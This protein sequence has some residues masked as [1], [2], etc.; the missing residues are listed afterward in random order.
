MV[1][2]QMQEE[3][4]L[5]Q[6]RGSHTHGAHRLVKRV[7]ACDNYCND[8]ACS[9]LHDSIQSSFILLIKITQLYLH[10]QSTSES[11]NNLKV[12]FKALSEQFKLN[13]IQNSMTNLQNVSQHPCRQQQSSSYVYRQA[14]VQNLEEMQ[15]SVF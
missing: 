14:S 1:N 9:T 3:T 4:C 10:T 15:F 13:Q 2:C 7:D 5:S 12:Y 8:R 11:L 6:V